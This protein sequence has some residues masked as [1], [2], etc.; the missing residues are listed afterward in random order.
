[1]KRETKEKIEVCKIRKEYNLGC[2][3]CEYVEICKTKEG[4]MIEKHAVQYKNCGRTIDYN[5]TTNKND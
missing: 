4:E 2:R 3:K 5:K 1:M